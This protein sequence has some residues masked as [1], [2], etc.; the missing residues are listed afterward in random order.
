MKHFGTK[1]LCII[2]I[3]FIVLG[4][5]CYAANIGDCRIS[6]RG[7]TWSIIDNMFD[8]FSFAAG[9]MWDLALVLLL[10][11]LIILACD[12]IG[13]K[14][15][16][17]EYQNTTTVNR[18]IAEHRIHCN[19]C[20]H[21]YCYTDKDLSQNAQNAGLGALSAI[22]SLASVLGGGTIF[23]THHLKGQADHY[24]DKIVDFKKCPNCNST[25]ITELTD[26]EFKKLNAKNPQASAP[27]ISNADEIKKY[28]EL[29][30]SGIITQEEFDAK[31]KQLL[32]L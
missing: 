29:L 12:K 4:I 20:G 18:D 3:L 30:D 10:I 19:V 17:V 6:H 5:V 31:K 25:N 28:K 26:E 27:T 32:G 24:T 13:E 16:L 1:L 23:H 9:F 7:T 11:A 8:P 22:G 14:A 15:S 2:A 21:L